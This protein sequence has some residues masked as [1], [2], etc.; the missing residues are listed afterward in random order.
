MGGE[1]AGL[2]LEPF[3]AALYEAEAAFSL[4]GVSAEIA[5]PLDDLRE[6]CAV[7]V[8]SLLERNLKAQRASSAGKDDKP[9]ETKP[10]KKGKKGKKAADEEAEAEPEAAKE[11]PADLLSV[12]ADLCRAMDAEGS[13][14]RLVDDMPREC[15]DVRGSLFAAL[16]KVA[17]LAEKIGK[18][19]AGADA[20]VAAASAVAPLLRVLAVL[21]LGG[22]G[23]AQRRR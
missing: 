18:G 19:G 6:A 20:S 14:A 13:G 4:E 2:L 23:R 15:A 22:G 1:L 9:A 3:G 10:A 11:A 21:Q 16:D 17:D 7:R 5:E 8:S 12:A